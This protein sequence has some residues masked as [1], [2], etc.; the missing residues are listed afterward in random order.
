MKTNPL[1]WDK[2]AQK[3][4]AQP[5][6]DPDAY[7]Y[8]LA[9]TRTYL[10]PDAHVL[11]IGCGTG[12]SALALA[13]T[14]AQITATDFAPE[15]IRIAKEKGAET[16]NV[17]FEVADT[18]LTQFQANQFDAVLAFNLFH[19]VGGLDAALARVAAVVKPGGYLISKTPCLG[20]A[21]YL[22][23]VIGL[24]RVVGKAPFV[25][26]LRTGQLDAQIKAAGFDVL[27]SEEHN[28]Q[29]RGHFVVARKV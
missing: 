26:F 21:W 14:G 15:M 9:Q 16:P 1:F 18:E 11:E 4:A 28:A 13:D 24:M 19:L 20:G 23:P 2:I 25:A 8:T 17:T 22:R 5:V 29:T 27:I 10:S 3:Y 12:S 6:S 7:A